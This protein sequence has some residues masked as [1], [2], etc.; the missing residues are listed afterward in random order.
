MVDG[1]APT[2][3]LASFT[4]TFVKIFEGSL[5]LLGNPFLMT[6]LSVQLCSD[7]GRKFSRVQALP[8]VLFGP[9][10]LLG[11]DTKSS[12]PSVEY[13]FDGTDARAGVSTILIVLEEQRAQHQRQFLG[14][15]GVRFVRGSDALLAPNA[16]PLNCFA[17]M[18]AVY[19]DEFPD[20][21][22]AIGQGL[23]AAG[24]AYGGHWGQRHINTPDVIE[25]WWGG[26][27]ADWKRAR[28]DLLPSP[29][30]QKVFASPIVASQS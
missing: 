18:Q 23:K 6:A 8:G 16:K 25:S 7:Y 22:E 4:S 5:D 10:K 19:T 17:E 24:I 21:L 20:V 2:T 28:K 14:G 12:G 3:D 30:A 1:S 29:I 26:A 13:V 9:P 27:A 11:I 15:I